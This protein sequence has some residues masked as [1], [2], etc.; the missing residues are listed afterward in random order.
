[1]YSV[2]II[3]NVLYSKYIRIYHSSTPSVSLFISDIP[4]SKCP[5]KRQFEAIFKRKYST[6]GNPFPLRSHSDQHGHYR[7]RRL[8]PLYRLC[9]PHGLAFHGLIGARTL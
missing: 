4:S 1:M 2:G 6:V 9:G 3:S 7:M 5:I 8:I